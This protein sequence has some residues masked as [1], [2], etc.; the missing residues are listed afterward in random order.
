MWILCSEKLRSTRIQGNLS[1]SKL[2]GKRMLHR[3]I[4]WHT[5]LEEDFVAHFVVHPNYQEDES[6]HRETLEN[7]GSSPFCK[8]TRAH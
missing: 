1:R 6:M 5:L 3:P 7:L 4:D 8:E 2:V